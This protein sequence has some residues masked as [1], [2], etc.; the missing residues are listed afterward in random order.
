MIAARSN[1]YTKNSQ[2]REEIMQIRDMEYAV[3]LAEAG[4]FSRAAERVFVTQPALSQ[5]IQRLED[6]LGVKLFN[7]ESSP[8]APTSAGEIFLEE[9]RSL[10]EIYNT[11]PKKMTDLQNLRRG[12]INIGI[13]QFYGRYYLSEIIHQFHRKYP[14]I[15]L[16]MVEEISSV[17]EDM[18]LKGRLDFCIFSLPIIAPDIVW[19]P[20]FEEEILFAVPKDHPLNATHLNSKSKKLSEVD[21][22][23]FAN[24]NFII[25]K[26]GQRLHTITLD[27]CKQMGFTPNIIFETR[28][29]ETANIFVARGMGVGF[30]PAGLL[31]VIAAKDRAVYYHLKSLNPKRT[32]VVAYHENHYLSNAAKAFIEFIS[33]TDNL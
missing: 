28:N 5:G 24:D 26:S 9:T 17:L 23:L 22:S 18:I 20:I 16:Y 2:I 1:P 27:F 13:S 3:A 6:E 32:F 30:V 31:R 10:L 14:G 8:L 4:G 12:K 19:K 11:I 15:E 33:P 25:I 29:V 21:L 7:R